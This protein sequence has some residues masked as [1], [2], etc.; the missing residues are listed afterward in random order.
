MAKPAQYFRAGVVIIVT[1]GTGR[2]LALRR[3]DRSED[4][5]QLPQGGLEEDEDPEHG[6][7]RELEEEA[8]LS[9]ESCRHV[10]TS[11]RWHAYELPEPFRSKKVGLG[12][13]QRWFV[14]RLVAGESAIEPD[15]REFDEWKWTTAEALLAEVVEFRRSAYAAAFAELAEA[16]RA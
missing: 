6:M 1:D 5:W 12:Q 11:E 8:G 4:A 2:V 3:A 7:W 16:L 10:A 14:C 15:G 9:R 13:V